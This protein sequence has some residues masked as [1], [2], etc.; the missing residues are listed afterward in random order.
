MQL[1]QWDF[2]VP[3][4]RPAR[5]GSCDPRVIQGGRR[6][7]AALQGSQ[8]MAEQAMD[9]A[10]ASPEATANRHRSNLA[11]VDPPPGAPLPLPAPPPEP[12]YKPTVPS[13]PV[14][15]KKAAPETRAQRVRRSIHRCNPVMPFAKSKVVVQTDDRGQT[16]IL[17]NGREAMGQFG[18]CVDRI[19]D[20]M[21]LSS[22]E[23]IKFQL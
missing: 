18:G 17:F 9:A 8:A 16:V 2:K 23:Q 1:L 10:P 13:A 5:A 6:A 3:M 15:E 21:R 11:D 20:R 12:T 4:V 19:A 22:G 14:V 7:G